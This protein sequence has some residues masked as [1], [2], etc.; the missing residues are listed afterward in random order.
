VQRAPG[1]PCA[2]IIE[3]GQRLSKNSGALRREIAGP[4]FGPA[5]EH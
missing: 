4:F 1:L 5:A 3:E 2:L